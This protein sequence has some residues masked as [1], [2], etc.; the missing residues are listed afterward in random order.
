MKKYSF[1]INDNQYTVLVKRVSD[2]N[3]KVEVNGIEYDV[4]IIKEKSEIKT[5]IIKE[6]PVVVDA[7][8]RSPM[9]DHPAGFDIKKPGNIVAPLPGLITKISVEVGDQVK[10][11][12]V[13]LIMEA[14]KME[15]EIQSTVSGEVTEIK[16]K[17]GD[18]VL[19]GDLLI[20]VG[21]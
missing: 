21:E 19:E 20:K 11:G 7:G 1:V 18:N 10:T 16:V 5:P 14:M 2:V 12:Q 3:A 13:V 6:N 4:K 17:P 9:T 8:S 15:N